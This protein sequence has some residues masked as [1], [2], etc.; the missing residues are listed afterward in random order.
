[1]IHGLF[2]LAHIGLSHIHQIFASEKISYAILYPNGIDK[3][4]LGVKLSPYPIVVLGAVNFLKIKHRFKKPVCVFVIDNPI[5]LE[6]IGAT[7]LGHTKISTYHYKFHPIKSNDIKIAMDS[8][9]EQPLEI[10]IKKSRVIADLLKA[11]SA[12]SMLSPLQTAFY[13]IKS[14]DSRTKVQDTVFEFLAGKSSRDYLNKILRK[15]AHNEEIAER[16]V[17]V[18]EDKKFKKLRKACS[19]VMAKKLP[20]DKAA[21][22]FHVPLYDLRYICKKQA[23]RLNIVLPG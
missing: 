15:R 19:L 4:D 10:K 8:C 5:Q 18:L 11:A 2:G 3:R 6:V 12:E 7:I 9:S 1:M 14:L 16:M 20:Y 22:R 23:A 13:Q 21:S 17:T